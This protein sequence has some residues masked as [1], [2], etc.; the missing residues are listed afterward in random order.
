M[1]KKPGDNTILCIEDEEDIRSFACKVLELEGY[2]CL[3][4]EDGREAFRLLKKEKINLVMLD[5]KLVEADGWQILEKI[6]NNPKTAAIP[7][8][9]CTASFGEVQEK[10]ALNMGAVAYLTKPLSADMLRQT[11]Q[12]ILPITR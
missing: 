8:V 5:L 2:R 12:R 11:V 7:V 10:R 1:V 6:K 3:Q 9:I 4:A